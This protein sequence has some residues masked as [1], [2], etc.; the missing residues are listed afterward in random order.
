[1]QYLNNKL[2]LLN[3]NRDKKSCETIKINLKYTKRSATD[4]SHNKDLFGN[5]FEKVAV[6]N[7]IF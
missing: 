3:M 7:P 1:M 4:M 6:K 2:H 5:E